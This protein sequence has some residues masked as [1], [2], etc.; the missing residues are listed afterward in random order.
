MEI[1]NLIKKTAK[2]NI[3]KKTIVFSKLNEIDNL[4]MISK[5]KL[6]LFPSVITITAGKIKA[7]PK[8]SKKVKTKTIKN[9]KNIL[10][11]FSK[12]K[13]LNMF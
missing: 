8:A 2:K 12:T 4:F 9:M 7:T 5:K 10:V 1:K 13:S 3:R 11:L 6:S